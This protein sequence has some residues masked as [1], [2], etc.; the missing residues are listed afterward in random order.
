MNG[1]DRSRNESCRQNCFT[2]RLL[3]TSDYRA[4]AV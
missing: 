1:L 3:Q 4:A 2:N